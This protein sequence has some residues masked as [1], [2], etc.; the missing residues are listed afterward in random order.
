MPFEFD[1]LSSFPKNFDL[2]KACH[3]MAKICFVHWHIP[4]QSP[5]ASHSDEIRGETVCIPVSICLYQYIQFLI[6][7]VYLQR[8]FHKMGIENRCIQPKKPVHSPCREKV[9]CQEINFE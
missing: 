3:G 6:G 1:Y 7:T 8:N 5:L 2:K 9:S 4:T